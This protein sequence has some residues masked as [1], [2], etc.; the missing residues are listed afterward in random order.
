MR[1]WQKYSYTEYLFG[2]QSVIF[3]VSDSYS[4]L[5]QNVGIQTDIFLLES[6]KKDLNTEEG[7]YAIDELPFSINHLACQNEDDEKAMYF[8]LDAT[9]TKVNRYCGIFF[10]EVATLENVLFLG[11]ISSKVS[12]TDKLW[13]GD[14][15]EF[16][17]NPKREYKFSAYSFDISMLDQVKLTGKIENFEGMPID[18][19]YQRFENEN[20]A[21]IKNIFQYR[22]SYSID[23]IFDN[24]IY[25]CPLGNLYKVLE[26]YLEKA[27]EIISE[28]SDTTITFNLVEGTLGVQT[29]PVSYNLKKETK[30]EINEIKA[31]QNIRIEL[32]LS[33]QSG[34]DNWSSPFIH[35]KMIDPA[36]GSSQEF[37]WQKNQISSELAYSFKSIDNISDLLFEIARSFG[38]YLFIS[39]T[40]GTS[41]NLEFKSRKGL[42]EDDYTYIIGT[43]EASFDTSSII[44]KD[45]KEFYGLA[46]NY[47]V[48]EFDDV[49]N[50]PNTNE[51]EPSQ[52]F[53]DADKQ[54]KYNKEN[55]GIESERLLLT[56]SITRVILC[57]VNDYGGHFYYIIPLNVTSNISDWNTLFLQII[58][59]GPGNG[60][61][62]SIERIHTGIYVKTKPMEETQIQRM[63]MVDIWRPAA[64]IYTKVNGTDLDFDSLSKYVNYIL[65]RDKYYYETEYS[66]T[67]PYWNGFSKNEDGSN[68]SW[69]NI[70]LGS[71][72][73]LT[74]TVKR[75]D[76]GTW[77]E[78]EVQRDYVVVG[79]EI[80]L[81][82]PETKLKL[83]NLERF[84]FGWWEG[85]EELLPLFMLS[86]EKESFIA[87][88]STIVQSYEIED[89]ET[90]LSGDAVMLLTSGKI[91]KSKSLSNYQNRTIG[92]AKE[93]GIG[94]ETI[95]VQISG[96]V[97]CDNYNFTNLSSPVFARTNNEGL[98]I[99][100]TIL[101]SPNYTEDMIICLGKIDS[102]NSFILNI[103]EFPFESGVLQES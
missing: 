83:H 21:S 60:T 89:N 2:E 41:L 53:Q 35:R 3:A 23:S 98:N 66:L 46:N 90:I 62:S 63:G 9:N 50:K 96:R 70:K 26:V 82:K 71:K 102:E 25:N 81:Q 37:D 45:S 94:G 64:R 54:R 4:E 43:S 13:Q 24:L 29:C 99:T 77:V 38:C 49:S 85:D 48:D 47:A 97:C 75:Y 86:S 15:F 5:F 51:A 78:E 18:N 57:A 1:F 68:P 33:D 88:N 61:S 34:G 103:F 74:E 6:V 14:D 20:W 8:V 69:K 44:T 39:Y 52:K 58:A 72:I 28:L 84:A 92:I 30:E 95:L 76:N 59:K 7:S 40:S 100:E 91:A 80:N 79:I 42:V 65:A 32:K 87:N 93:S 55:K 11:K 17:V 22:L 12:G 56:T 10:G 36:L 101:D 31:E 16:N 73:K 27:T 67:V 19:V